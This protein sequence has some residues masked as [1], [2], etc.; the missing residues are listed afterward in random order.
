MKHSCRKKKEVQ[1]LFFNVLAKPAYVISFPP[2]LAA[3][4]ALSLALAM[5]ERVFCV[6]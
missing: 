4:K 3:V 5:I 6:L 1:K 2:V